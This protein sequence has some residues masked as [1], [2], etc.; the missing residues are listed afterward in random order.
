MKNW[1]ALIIAFL[2]LGVS[3]FVIVF[4][5]GV[6][7]DVRGIAGRMVAVEKGLE[8]T[9]TVPQS[10]VEMEQR[11]ADLEGQLKMVKSLEEE[12][13]ALSA[14]LAEKGQTLEDLSRARKAMESSLARLG[15]DLNTW[16]TKITALEETTK[17]L[18]V[19][20]ESL[21]NLEQSI[22]ALSIDE[23]FSALLQYSE[24]KIQE[25]RNTL[26][27][28]QQ[29]VTAWKEKTVP[30]EVFEK[31]LRT[32]EEKLQSLEKEL[33]EY[34]KRTEESVGT[35]RELLGEV[36]LVQ[37]DYGRRLEESLLTFSQKIA[38]LEEELQGLSQSVASFE[39]DFE[40]VQVTFQ[41]FSQR[42]SGLQEKLSSLESGMDTWKETT[43]Q[44]LRKEVEALAAALPS[45]QDLEEVRAEVVTLLEERESLRARFQELAAE[46]ANIV[47]ELEGK[48]KDILAL[49]EKIATLSEKEEVTAFARGLV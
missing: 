42:L 34:E 2:A 30:L 21:K 32:L 5:T 19:L 37:K 27:A 18:E 45:P 44:S 1:L 20:K 25:V 28:L 15:E 29:E 48:G 12:I 26:S 9:R 23:R 46:Q 47:Q 41:E 43:L 4:L 39:G 6:S 10:V 31:A 7:R 13:R 16:A 40:K 22:A 35:I 24:G 38:A 3:L 33:T 11:I 36:Q 14:T 8:E 49:K 17:E